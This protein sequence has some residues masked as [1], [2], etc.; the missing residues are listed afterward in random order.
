VEGHVGS[1]KTRLL[2]ELTGRVRLQG[3]TVVIT[4]AVEADREDA[5]GGILALA[6]GGLLEAP[7]VAGASARA[8]GALAHAVPEWEARFP[9][10][11]GQGE[12]LPFDRAVEELL[13]A[14]SEERPVL[15]VVDDAHWLDRESTLALGAALR[16]LVALPFAVLLAFQPELPRP[17]LDEIR[18]RIG[19]ELAG[20]AVTLGPLGGEGLRILARHFLPQYSPLELDRVVRRVS[21]DSAG[22]PFLASELLRAVAHGLDLGRV[23]GTWPEPFK[24][25]DQT[26][27]GDLPDT[28]VAALRVTFRRLSPRAQGV[29]SAAAVI[30]ERVEGAVLARVTELP[31]REVQSALDELEWHQWLV[32]EVRGY[33]FAAR[34]TRQVIAEDMVSPGQRR[35]MLAAMSDGAPSVPPRS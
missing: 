9:A 30:G 11:T 26:L 22:V 1:G 25:L 5:R 13:R 4:R 23:S 27:P 20:V 24:T 33:S 28:V 16:D 17:E 35:R 3:V 2:D 34:L 10:A 21:T 31:L 8:L 29:L 32:A 19:R 14:A 15:L 18:S 7:G 12:P 6:R